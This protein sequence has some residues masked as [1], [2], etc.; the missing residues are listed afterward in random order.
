[1]AADISLFEKAILKDPYVIPLNDSRFE[2][3]LQQAKQKLRHFVGLKP[4]SETPR[5]YLSDPLHDPNSLFA[6]MMG[7]DHKKYRP[8]AHITNHARMIYFFDAWPKEYHRIIKFVND[9]SIDRIFVSASQSADDLNAL[10]NQKKFHH[11]PEGVDPSVYR[12]ARYDLKNIDVLA[13]GRK[14]DRYHERILP[15]LQRFDRTYMYEVLKGHIIFPDREGLIDGLARTK[16]SICVP[17]S[18]THPERS[19]HVETMTMRYLQSMASKCL[20]LGHAPAEMINL[21]GYNPVIEIDWENA[22]DQIL[23]LLQH[24]HLHIPLIERNYRELVSKH[25]WVHRFQ[26]IKDILAGAS[27]STTFG[28]SPQLLQVESPVSIIA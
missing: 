9:Y 25:T 15:A 6:V 20:I 13:L 4:F 16:I 23:D 24:F 18:I 1:L 21:F 7:L 8:H 12:Y 5:R 27:A 19:G 22:E 11:V 14:Y 2:F 26:Q 28:K 3:G 10:L 17:G